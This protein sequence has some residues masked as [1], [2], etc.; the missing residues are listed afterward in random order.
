MFI[1]RYEY[2]NK[3]PKILIFTGAG[4]SAESGI[5]TFRDLNG[6]WENHNIDQICDINTWE[7][8]FK[9]VHEF[10]NKRREELNVVKP[11][12]AHKIIANIS[13][14]YDTFVFTQNI[15]NLLE[16]AG[17]K[18]VHH[19]HG[20]LT[21][22]QCQNCY[23]K[24][25]IGHTKHDINNVCPICNSNNIKPYIVFFGESAPEYSMLNRALEYMNDPDTTII[26][27]GTM[28]NVIPISKKI[29]NYCNSIKIL[30]N[31]EKS[32][33]INEYQFNYV[34]Y[35]PATEAWINIED[36][37]NKKYKI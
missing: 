22:L 10:Y 7:K 5:S 23:Y 9:L 24:Y 12:N 4:I 36:I 3:K 15:D 11:N 37:L 19:L 16:R 28:G 31:L 26:V 14:K 18:E 34:F 13:N 27:S 8:N 21:K 17:C 30:N 20:E 2:A 33:Y 25:D 32:S 35:Q 1:D 29:D 6:I